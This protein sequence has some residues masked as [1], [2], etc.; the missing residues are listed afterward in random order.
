MELCHSRTG[1]AGIIASSIAQELC[2]TRQQP[3]RPVESG[4]QS[5]AASQK[6]LDFA[7]LAFSPRTACAEFGLR[8]MIG[9]GQNGRAL[10]AR[11][12][13]LTQKI[14]SIHMNGPM[15]GDQASSPLCHRICQEPGLLCIGF[16]A[17]T[18]RHKQQVQRAPQPAVAL[19]KEDHSVRNLRVGGPMCHSCQTNQGLPEA[20]GR[21]GLTATS[22]L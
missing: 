15:L 20:S 22:P 7:R 12:P 2:R 16:H 13:E 14:D 21:F 3:P 5:N 10:P 4:C 6:T 8:G 1:R 19:D 11:R 9:C 18:A 17:I